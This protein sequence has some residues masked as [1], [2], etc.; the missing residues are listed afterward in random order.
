MKIYKAKY[1]REKVILNSILQ[2]IFVR[3]V[4]HV[5]II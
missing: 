3:K 4:Y 5:E 2:Y 1:K